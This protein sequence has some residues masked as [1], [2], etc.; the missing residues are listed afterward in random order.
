MKFLLSLLLIFSVFFVT[1]SS[2]KAN[3]ASESLV[4]YQVQTAGAVSGTATEEL[5]F[6]YNLST[7]PVNVSDWC[8]VYSS[9]NDNVGFEACVDRPDELTDIWLESGGILS[10]A[11]PA[12][13]QANSEF[14]EDFTM[15][16]GMSSSGGHIRII[17]EVDNEIDKIGWGGA[18]A[19]EGVAALPHDTGEVLSRDLTK[20]V[21]DSDD[22]FVDF[23]SMVIV[24]E[25][26]SGL[27]EEER[28]IDLCSNIDGVQAELPTGY[29]QD[30]VDACFEDVCI[31]IEGL[32]ISLPE[33]YEFTA[34]LECSTVPLED[35]VIFITELLPNA[36]SVDTGQEFIELFNPNTTSVNLLGY[37]L[38]LGPS[39]TKR[40]IFEEIE[41][42]PS[43][44]KVFSDTETGIVL[45][46]SNGAALRLISPFGNVVS[47]SSVYSNAQDDESWS[48]VEDQWI[49]TN[50]ITPEAANRP[51]LIE[52]VNEVA[53]VTSVLAPC[54]V[55]K[56]RNP[57]T[58]RCKNIAT[59]TSQ[60]QPCGADEFRNPETNRCKK[61]DSGTAALGPCP[62][63]QER[64]PDTNRC[65]T[66]ATLTSGTINPSQTVTDIPVEEVDG[67]INWAIIIP[68]LIATVLYIVYEWRVE[69]RQKI[70]AF[71]LQISS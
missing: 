34:E 68:V 37:T 28:I 66:V 65:R 9:V 56:F 22:N 54:P 38:E 35:S 59:T 16:G 27:Y 63:G 43:Q 4:I 18:I 14:Q 39:F 30:E 12:F 2:A 71:R 55:G 46:N 17:D 26:S 42:L 25:I 8:I 31:N 40:H 44:Y 11:T 3:A 33:G 52:S 64:N 24:S 15:P 13:I 41:I 20:E 49:W 7:I 48:L 67:S 36:P 69:I 53:G 50:Q 6:L 23:S 19:P 47:E 60:L 62:E 61:I 58:N 29:L 5:I 21:I 1:P 51:F 10:F 57:E 32:Q 70:K 45:P